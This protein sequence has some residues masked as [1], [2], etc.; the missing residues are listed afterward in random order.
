MTKKNTTP[1]VNL[2]AALDLLRGK[3]VVAHDRR[4]STATAIDFKDYRLPGNV[5]SLTPLYGVSDRM[6]KAL[7]KLADKVVLVRTKRGRT[8]PSYR[9]FTDVAA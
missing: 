3:T 9:F 1:N 7:A 8:L 2:R 5:R 6:Q 4:H